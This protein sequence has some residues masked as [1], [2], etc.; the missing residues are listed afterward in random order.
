VAVDDARKIELEAFSG[1]GEGLEEGRRKYIT[2]STQ[3]RLHQSSFRIRVIRAYRQYCAICRL[4]H[5][6]L[7]EAAHIIPDKDPRGLPTITN[8]LALC[9]LHHRAFDRNVLGIRPDCRIELRQDILDEEDGP[10]LRHGLQ[11]FQ[12]KAILLP[13]REV[14]RPG[15]CNLEERYELFRKAG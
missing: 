9:A 4:N 12:G 15:R 13:R 14:E 6:E 3:V 7:L 10:M 2:A 5:P 8:G 11:G 1:A